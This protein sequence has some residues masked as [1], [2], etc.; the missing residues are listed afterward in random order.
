MLQTK[1]S[2]AISG[3]KC[4]YCDSIIT[5]VF[6]WWNVKIASSNNLE[7]ATDDLLL[8]EQP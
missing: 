2:C 3:E 1:F 7:M 8:Y 5:E 6:I 4:S